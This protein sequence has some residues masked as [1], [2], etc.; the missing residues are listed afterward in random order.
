LSEGAAPDTSAKLQEAWFFYAASRIHDGRAAQQMGDLEAASAAFAEAAKLDPA[1]VA[2]WAG[3]VETLPLGDEQHNAARHLIEVAGGQSAKL[4]PM[5]A[6]LLSRGFALAA[7]VLWREGQRQEPDLPVWPLNM[8]SALMALGREAEAESEAMAALALD[9]QCRE[10][11]RLLAIRRAA[12]GEFFAGLEHFRQAQPLDAEA[13]T[14]LGQTLT[15]LGDMDEAAK[16]FARAAALEPAHASSALM[17]M[18]YSLKFTGEEIARAHLEWG[19]RLPPPPRPPA[20][21]RKEQEPLRI[22]FVSADFRQHATG[23]FLPPLLEHRDPSQWLAYLYSNVRKPDA[24]TARFTSLADVWRDIAHLDDAAAARLVE[25]DGIDILIDLNGHTAGNRLGLFALR[26]AHVQ[27][28]YLDYVGTTGLRQIDY[29]IRDE[30]HAPASED[31]FFS[32]RVIRLPLDV[33]SYKPPAYAPPIAPP[34]WRA[35]GFVTF[36]CVNALS[37]ISQ[38]AIAV[39]CAILQALPAARFVLA[40]PSL[41]YEDARTRT[42]KLFAQG[43]IDPAR[44]DLLGETDHASQLARYAQIDLILDSFPYSGGLSTLEAL[45]MGVPVVTFPGDR[46]GARHSA[47]HLHFIGCQDLIAASLEG[48]AEM[49]M[50][51]GQAPSQLE[52]F[53]TKLRQKLASSS[54]VDGSLYASRFTEI[55]HKMR[56]EIVQG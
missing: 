27:A 36:G 35:N 20:H 31:G 45:W 50:H 6:M 23:I 43:G 13:E 47:C 55:L 10:A 30:I 34:P 41:K 48:Y 16:A 18:H 15:L 49:A 54:I 7:L 5:A 38:A 52:P 53:R 12:R 11:H 17:A 28:T 56:R 51:F 8:A 1:N 19:Q 46:M 25:E 14:H 33:F 32:E 29:L 44:L 22:G 4:G 9:P 26:P 37:K 24:L 21:P 42:R 39:W 40:A 3:L 2:A